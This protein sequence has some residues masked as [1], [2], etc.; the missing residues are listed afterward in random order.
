M[1]IMING[2]FGI[3]KTSVAHLLNDK[4][5]NSMIYDPEDIGYMLREIVVRTN[6]LEV[7]DDYQHLKLWC[8]L[9]V[10]VARQLQQHYQRH[11]IVPMTL[12]FP[13]YF[14]KIK[15]GFSNFETT[16]HHFCLM[17]SSDTI[18]QRLARRGEQPNCWAEQQIPRCLDAFATYDYET[19]ID[20]ENL[21]LD[22][23]TELIFKQIR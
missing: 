19:Y 13:E 2:A 5:P 3:G 8:D 1:I 23:V 21:S 22:A 6:H 9:T 4:L 12:A 11:L 20:T 16:V 18:R 14:Y 15:S 17:A 10:D 7:V